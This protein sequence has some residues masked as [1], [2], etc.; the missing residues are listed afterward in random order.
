[1]TALT[2]VTIGLDVSD[3]LTHACMLDQ[4]G[5][6]GGMPSSDDPS[7]ARRMSSAVSPQAR[8]VLEAGPHSPW[9]SRLL[10]GIGHDVVVA[11][12]RRVQLIAQGDRKADRN[13]ARQ[14]AQLG[15]N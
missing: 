4:G 14:L 10:S 6:P 5:M 8:K 2:A 9:I 13:D 15:R 7:A 12:S 3:R 11:N 1:M